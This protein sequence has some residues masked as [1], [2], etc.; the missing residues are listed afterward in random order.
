MNQIQEVFNRLQEAKKEQ[1]GLKA[2]YKEALDNTPGYKELQEEL[3]VLKA[4]KKEFELAVQSDFTKE[5]EQ[6]ESIKLD[7]E[8]DNMMISDLAVNHLVKGEKIEVKDDDENEYEP[9][10]TVRF[11]KM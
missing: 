7:L 11:K 9:M 2:C 6:L 3:K 5:F 4:K 8:S 1:K 10:I